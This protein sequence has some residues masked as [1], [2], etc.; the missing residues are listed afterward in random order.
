MLAFLLSKQTVTPEVQAWLGALCAVLIGSGFLIEWIA[1]HPL[2][3]RFALAAGAAG[4]V[5]MLVLYWPYWYSGISF[6]G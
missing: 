2:V 6:W 1:R 4:T 5:A 3:K